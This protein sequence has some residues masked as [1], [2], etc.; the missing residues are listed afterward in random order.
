MEIFR[1]DGE[2]EAELVR[3]LLDSCGVESIIAGGSFRVANLFTLNK[4]G[5]VRILVRAVDA[6]RAREVLDSSFE[7]L[8][9]FGE[10]ED[11]QG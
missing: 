6:A 8:G 1:A 3:S 11:S 2:M 10:A 7:P 9:D 5:L 4:P